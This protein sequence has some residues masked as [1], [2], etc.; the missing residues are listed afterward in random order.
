MDLL[1]A[2]LRGG[3]GRTIFRRL[4]HTREF[5]SHVASILGVVNDVLMPRGYKRVT[6]DGFKSIV[7]LLRA[8]N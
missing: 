6:D 3:I 5:Q 2:E 4:E 1:V 7:Q 8:S